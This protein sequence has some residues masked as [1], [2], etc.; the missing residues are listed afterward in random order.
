MNN[1][2]ERLDIVLSDR[3]KVE[4]QKRLALV[5]CISQGYKDSTTKSRP[6]YHSMKVLCYSADFP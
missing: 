2:S 1:S 3:E 5:K 4:F 6:L